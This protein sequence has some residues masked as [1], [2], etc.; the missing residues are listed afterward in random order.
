MI[1]YYGLFKQSFL[2]NFIEPNMCTPAV[3]TIPC[4]HSYWVLVL[5]NMNIK[6]QYIKL[7]Y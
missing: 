2:S 3:T 7:F 4:I 6:I 1:C 5:T